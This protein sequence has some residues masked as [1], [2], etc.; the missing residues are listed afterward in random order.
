MSEKV[1]AMSF[2]FYLNAR[3]VYKNHRL[4]E[5]ESIEKKSIAKGRAGVK[6]SELSR[7]SGGPAVGL[8]FEAT[9]LREDRLQCLIV[10]RAGAE[11]V[12]VAGGPVGSV[13]PDRKKH[14]AFEQ[15]FFRLGRA[16]EAVKPP[17]NTVAHEHEVKG[18]LAALA[19]CEQAL[20]DGGGQIPFRFRLYV[21]LSK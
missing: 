3:F 5:K 16:T 6:C 14:R 11:K 9:Q 7:V 8:R 13:R 17:L 2:C 20:P 15:E 12:H 4:I 10:V 21:R 18:L 1:I 19:Q